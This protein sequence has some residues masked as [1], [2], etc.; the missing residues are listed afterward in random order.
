[1]WVTLQP[2]AAQPAACQAELDR[3]REMKLSLSVSFPSFIRLYQQQLKQAG[4]YCWIALTNNL[5]SHC[6]KNDPHLSRLCN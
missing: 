1:M 4:I 5:I 6:L 3:G 2:G